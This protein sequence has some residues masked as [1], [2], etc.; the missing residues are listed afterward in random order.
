M[1]ETHLKQFLVCV[2]HGSKNRPLRL[3]IH[4][5]YKRVYLCFRVSLVTQKYGKNKNMPPLYFHSY[6]VNL[7]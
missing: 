7:N 1:V 3:D 6:I 4:S 5:L 2:T